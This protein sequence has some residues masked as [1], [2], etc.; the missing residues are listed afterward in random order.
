MVQ[1][2]RQILRFKSYN[3]FQGE[4]SSDR[5]NYWGIVVV[6]EDAYIPRQLYYEKAQEIL[7]L[8]EERHRSS[9]EE[10]IGVTHTSKTDATKFPEFKNTI[11]TSN[12]TQLSLFQLDDPLIYQLRDQ[13][14]NIDI[15]N[16]TPL[17]ALNKISE[18]KKLLGI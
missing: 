11:E 7:Q 6:L 2:Y 4:I 17:E 8:L 13:I 18:I 1:L 9:G 15:N 5:D 10:K 14:K 16:I 12:G 3:P